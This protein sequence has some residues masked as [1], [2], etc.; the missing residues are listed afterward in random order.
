MCRAKRYT[1]QLLEIYD[2][3][4]QDLKYFNYQIREYQLLE[5]DVL[6]IIE[7][8]KFNAAEGCKLANMIKYA[9]NKRRDY[10]IEI[11]TML[12]L[13]ETFIDKNI[14]QLK[15]TYDSVKRQ[16]E[17]LLELKRNKVYR[18][19]VLNSMELK[20]VVPLNRKVI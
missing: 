14:E 16:D 15:D 5:Q 18:P 1:E 11:E 13:K 10:K 17:I 20:K 8:K 2:N 7:N 19:R 3:I 4:N 12:N 6:H 9:R